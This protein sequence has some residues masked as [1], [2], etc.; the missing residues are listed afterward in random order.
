MIL[1]LVPESNS[2][3]DML[4]SLLGMLLVMS[5]RLRR[6]KSIIFN[7]KIKVIMISILADIFVSMY[8]GVQRLVII[9][10]VMIL[11]ARLRTDLDVIL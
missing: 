4:E 8:A 3:D 11:C 7:Q 10:Y 5:S 1:S 6:M 9:L 2:L